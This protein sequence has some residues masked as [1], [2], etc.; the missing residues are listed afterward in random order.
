MD[1]LE[2]YLEALSATRILCPSPAI[3][4]K[5]LQ[6][7]QVGTRAQSEEFQEMDQSVNRNSVDGMLDAAGVRLGLLRIELQGSDK[8][9]PQGV[10]PAHNILR[11]MASFHGESDMT[12]WTVMDEPPAGQCL[13]SPRH[14]SA[15]NAHLIRNLFG[16]SHTMGFLQMEDHLEIIFQACRKPFRKLGNCILSSGFV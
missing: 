15:L 10:V 2:T 6:P 3:E 12:V 5:A 1:L 14:R 7:F 11:N 4:R 13:Q 16:A 8:E 9:F